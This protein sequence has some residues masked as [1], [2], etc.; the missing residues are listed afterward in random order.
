MLHPDGTI[1]ETD[2][3]F[4]ASQNTKNRN[5]CFRFDLDHYHQRNWV[6]REVPYPNDALCG[7]NRMRLYSGKE[8]SDKKGY[9][10]GD[11]SRSL[12]SSFKGGMN[13]I[14]GKE[15]YEFG[16]LSRWLDAQAK[17]KVNEFTEKDKYQF[18]DITK[19]I[20]R[21]VRSGEYTVDDIIL[22]C[23][24]IVAIGVNFQPI[25]SVLP[26]KLLMEMLDVSIAQ[27]LSGKLVNMLSKEVDKR[28][29]SALLGDENYEV[30][31]LT[32]RAISQ[33]TGKESVS[34]PSLNVFIL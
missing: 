21:R 27:D 9:Q 15:S 2:A 28:M 18:G 32:K 10:F 26:V 25:A 24:V 3:A 31:D 5:N 17:D 6:S 7:S 30:G 34:Y 33:F 11:I 22:L 1:V 12:L 19:E 14:T 23:K 4:A 29:K 16:D 13:Q 8:G 20:I